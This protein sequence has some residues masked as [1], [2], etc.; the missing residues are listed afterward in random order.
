MPSGGNG[1]TIDVNLIDQLLLAFSGS[2]C[3]LEHRNT[4]ALKAHSLAGGRQAVP[5]AHHAATWSTGSRLR[6]QLRPLDEARDN[7]SKPYMVV[8]SGNSFSAAPSTNGD[9]RIKVIGVGGG[10]CCC[11]QQSS[12]C[13]RSGYSNRQLLLCSHRWWQRSQPYVGDRPAGVPKAQQLQQLQSTA[14]QSWAG[15]STQQK[16]INIVSG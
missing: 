4:M 11:M 1:I 8:R 15:W 6:R 13:T 5:R 2:S 12:S 7:S 10:G 14:V 16:V 3:Q 9:A